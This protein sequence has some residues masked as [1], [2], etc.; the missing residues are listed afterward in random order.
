M[1]LLM[2]ALKKAEQTK[3]QQAEE[4]LIPKN[5][6]IVPSDE[7]LDF[8]VGNESKLTLEEETLSAEPLELGQITDQEIESVTQSKVQE[9]P[10]EKPAT[11]AED[12]DHVTNPIAPIA[13]QDQ[14][15]I[16]TVPQ[17][18]V[19]YWPRTKQHKSWF[20][21]GSVLALII[22]GAGGAYYFIDA[23]DQLGENSNL[24]QNSF[25]PIVDEGIA[26]HIDVTEVKKAAIP[27]TKI[28]QSEKTALAPPPMTAVKPAAAKKLKITQQKLRR[29]TSPPKVSIADIEHQKAPLTIVRKKRID[30]VDVL[31]QDAYRAYLNGDYNSANGLYQKVLGLKPGN[32]DALIGLAVIAHRNQQPVQAR[33]YYKKILSLNPKDSQAA[34][35]LITLERGRNATE[36][37]SRLKLLLEH[38]PQAAYLHFTLGNQYVGQVRWADAQQAF[39]QAYHADPTNA[40]YAFNLAV[41]LDQLKQ[42]KAALQYYRQTLQLARGKT[43]SFNLFDVAKRIKTLTRDLTR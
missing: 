8:I 3:Q 29:A 7:V 14:P 40:D 38:E 34:A 19:P 33:F 9:T 18:P 10:D 16:P 15:S 28:H 5:D 1:S 6:S 13:S 26:H 21:G 35:G 27:D 31:L 41:S 30:P 39:F 43:V 32:R 24:S 36:T 11:Q 23:L 25:Q 2:N 22:L 17:A 42:T 12:N 4:N 37:E 20:I